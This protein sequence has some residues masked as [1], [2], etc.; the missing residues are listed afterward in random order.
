M[1]TIEVTVTIDGEPY[2]SR[3]ITD[4][5]LTAKGIAEKYNVPIISTV[6]KIFDGQPVHN[7]VYR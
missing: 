3:K 5:N 4:E 7:V 6:S 1:S 2:S